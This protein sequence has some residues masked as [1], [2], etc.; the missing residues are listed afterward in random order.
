MEWGFVHPKEIFHRH[1]VRGGVRGHDPLICKSQFGAF[2]TK[3]P[4]L[5]GSI[6]RDPKKFLW[7][8]ALSLSPLATLVPFAPHEL[9]LLQFRR[10]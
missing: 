10:Q 8:S 9:I 4:K 7:K 5:K 3:V 1:E 2:V 6:V